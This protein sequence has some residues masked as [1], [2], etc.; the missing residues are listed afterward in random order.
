MNYLKSSVKI[1]KTAV[2]A[3]AIYFLT[4]CSLWAC[5]TC[6]SEYSQEKIDAYLATT[7]LLI[8][9]P[10]GFVGSVGFYVYRKIKAR[11]KEIE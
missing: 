3:T 10:I 11:Q 1:G 6:S 2:L 5:Y 7:Y 4:Q 8:A 9:L